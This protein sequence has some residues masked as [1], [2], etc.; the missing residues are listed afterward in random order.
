MIVNRILIKFETASFKIIPDTNPKSFQNLLLLP[1]RNE[2][3]VFPIRKSKL[4]APFSIFQTNISLSPSRKPSRNSVLENLSKGWSGVDISMEN[5]RNTRTILETSVSVNE[6][7]VANRKIFEASAIRKET[8]PD[9]NWIRLEARF[10]LVK[11]ERRLHGSPFTV[12]VE[13]ELLI[14]ANQQISMGARLLALWGKTS[15][16]LSRPLCFAPW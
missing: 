8:L 5:P 3:Q 2:S 4:P 7:K 10:P 6:N 1:A 13:K 9:E 16:L 15:L 14:C 11:G 12:L